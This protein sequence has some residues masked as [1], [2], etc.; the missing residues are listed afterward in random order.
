MALGAASFAAAFAAFALDYALV[1]VT[2]EPPEVVS[3]SGCISRCETASGGLVLSVADAED[4]WLV[5]DG[6]PEDVALGYELV[7]AN[8]EVL[9]QGEGN[10][11]P[12]GEYPDAVAV[13]VYS[14]SG[15]ADWNE[16]SEV[17][18]ESSAESAEVRF[19]AVRRGASAPGARQSLRTAASAGIAVAEA[20]G[21]L[22][23][24]SSPATLTLDPGTLYDSDTVAGLSRANPS[25]EIASIDDM[26]ETGNFPGHGAF[27]LSASGYIHV[28]AG[29][30]FKV[31]ADDYATLVVGGVSSSVD[32]R[33]GFIWGN[34]AVVS[35]GGFT[36]ATITFGSYGGPYEFDLD[37]LADRTFY[38]GTPIPYATLVPDPA[39][40]KI[41]WSGLSPSCALTI[42]PYDS[43]VDYQVTQTDGCG[44]LSGSGATYTFTPDASAFLGS[45][46]PSSTA[47]FAMSQ[48]CCGV[49]GAPGTASVTLVRDEPNA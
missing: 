23:L 12:L 17:Y 25:K 27:E 33:T 37:G 49:S 35:E 2:V 3:A 8:G 15:D 6:L 48:T 40:L 13:S 30:T 9:A 24:E 44:T 21:F 26:L 45:G 42:S 36:S 14:L 41:P 20:S 11:L 38:A 31:G 18:A 34:Q 1:D 19:S 43:R 16:V 22:L 32:G 28:M 46:Q 39:E 4:V 5:F 29:D 47:S 7:G 10:Y